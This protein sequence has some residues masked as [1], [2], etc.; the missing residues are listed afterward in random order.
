MTPEE[1]RRLMSYLADR[2]QLTEDRTVSFEMPSQPEMVDTGFPADAV[3]RLLDAPWLEEMV[4]DVRETPEYCDPDAAPAEV[5]QYARDTVVEYLR[6][7][8]EP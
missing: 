1:I 8:F 2:V 3:R 5:L 7:R 4:T 6:K